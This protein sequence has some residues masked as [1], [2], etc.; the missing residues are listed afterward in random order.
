MI[1]PQGA[2]DR[3]GGEYS[4]TA[5]VPGPRCVVKSSPP[6]LR[7]SGDDGFQCRA[8]GFVGDGVERLRTGAHPA[9][10]R[11]GPRADVVLYLGRRPLHRVQ[12]VREQHL[13]SQ[14][15]GCGHRRITV[16]DGNIVYVTASPGTWT[17][18]PTRPACRPIPGRPVLAHH[19]RDQAFTFR[20]REIKGR[21]VGSG[22]GVVCSRAGR[23]GAAGVGQSSS[24]VNWCSPWPGALLHGVINS[25]CPPTSGRRIAERSASLRLNTCSTVPHSTATVNRPARWSSVL[26]IFRHRYPCQ[27]RVYPMG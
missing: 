24:G 27:A 9:G 5:T 21:S 19:E 14:R 3:G 11:K 4:A 26:M 7:W 13:G 18:G 22:P 12:L 25:R 10:A 23:S 15:L 6:S 8:R 2:F 16:I 20:R 1:A 17:A